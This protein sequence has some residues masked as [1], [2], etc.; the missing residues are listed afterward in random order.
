[1]KKVRS[2]IIGC[3]SIAGEKDSLADKYL[4]S[5]AKAY[6]KNKYTE[7]VGVC[8]IDLKKAKKFAK[9][10]NLKH[11]DNSIYNIINKSNPNLVSICTPAS[12][13]REIILLLAKLKIRKIWLE[14]PAAKSVK[15]LNEII[16]ISEK[17]K[18]KIW[19]NYF[20]LYE[21]KLINLKREINKVSSIQLINCFYTKGLK[22]NGSH[23]LSMLFFLL[24]NEYRIKNIRKDKNKDYPGYSFN[25]VQ[26]NYVI[27]VEVLDEKAFEI[28]EIDIIGKKGRI[29][30][31][32]LSKN[33]DIFR[34]KK[35][36]YTKYYK[37]LELSKNLNID[38]HNSFSRILNNILSDK[39][40]WDLK[41]E[42]KV[43]TLI[44]KISKS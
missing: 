34:V 12:T 10:W 25:L 22:N 43:E 21:P 13:H 1:M 31:S 20:R 14:K 28:F 44:N 42:M 2:V 29:I 41:K 30:I 32:N 15:D 16:K 24:G 23:L 4:R 19:I 6:A 40:N 35:N 39:N 17:Y 38:L 37:N 9:K 7:L 27:N 3:G 8:D 18:I 5:H 11:Y 26:K 36:I 33:I